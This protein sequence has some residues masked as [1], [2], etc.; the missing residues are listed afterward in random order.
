MTTEDVM[1]GAVTGDRPRLEAGH[2]IAEVAL[3]VEGT[4]WLVTLELKPDHAHHLR[5]ERDGH[6]AVEN[7]G[8]VPWDW[9]G[10]A[11][12]VEVRDAVAALCEGMSWS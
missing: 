1:H 4:A 10:I 9:P 6:L 12:P 2:L 11:F 7:V 5:V 3:D 8:S